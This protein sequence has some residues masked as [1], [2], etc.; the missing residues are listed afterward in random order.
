VGGNVSAITPSTGVA[1]A[2]DAARA[3]ANVWQIDDESVDR[4]TE[5]LRLGEEAGASAVWVDTQGGS[6][7]GDGVNGEEYRQSE[8]SESLGVDRR[9]SFDEGYNTTG[10]V[11]T[12]DQSH[13][14]LSNGNADVRGE[15]VGVYS[16]WVSNQGV[17]ADVVARVGR[18][19]N[20]YASYDAFGTT[21]GRYRA[22]SSSLAVRVGKR[23]QGRNG[24]YIEPQVQ[25]AYGSVGAI[26]YNASNNVRFDVNRNHTFFSR[27]GVLAG[28]AFSLATTVNGD[29][30]ARASMLHTVGDR[31]DLTAS[32]DGGSLPVVTSARHATTGEVG[33]GAHVALPRRLSVF[34]E[35]GDSSRAGSVAGGWRASAGLRLSF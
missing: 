24:M 4:R 33:V 26:G 25:A 6:L 14:D 29:V 31:P 32:L 27:A 23:F 10:V 17:F 1:V 12:H 16:S 34:A 35:V 13:A 3:L 18:L 20:S 15:S 8:T 30:Y 22:P 5:S 9:I 21:Y 19:C 28:K 11:Y 7:R 2:A